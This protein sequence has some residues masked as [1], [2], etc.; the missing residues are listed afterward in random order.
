MPYAVL[1]AKLSLRYSAEGALSTVFCTAALA[2][3][4]KKK[5]ISRFTGPERE[6]K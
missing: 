1:C 2:Q 3:K 4:K 5:D 6:N